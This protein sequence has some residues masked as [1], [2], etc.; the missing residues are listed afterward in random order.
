MERVNLDR[1][2]AGLKPNP[3]MNYDEWKLAHNIPTP[4]PEPTPTAKEPDPQKSGGE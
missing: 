3:I 1:E 4:A 2:K